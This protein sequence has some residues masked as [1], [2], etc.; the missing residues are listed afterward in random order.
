MSL[1]PW[2][3]ILFLMQGTPIED[4]QGEEGLQP[5]L[6]VER[7]VAALQAGQYEQAREQF[8]AAYQLNPKDAILLYRLSVVEFNLGNH[9][10]AR[11]WLNRAHAELV[12]T[13]FNPPPLSSPP[14][15][16]T[17]PEDSARSANVAELLMDG[18]YTLVP[19]SKDGWLLRPKSNQTGAYHLDVGSL[20]R[21]EL[22][23]EKQSRPK[24]LIS[25]PIG[26]LLVWVFA[27]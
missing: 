26:L 27:R 18:E 11:L 25:I 9:D 20:Y 19:V 1:I 23:R 2:A 10:L 21:M 8:M 16:G 14:A 7:G 13:G 4:V 12:E 17:G 5:S 24:T 15:G 22:K 6:Y 3:L